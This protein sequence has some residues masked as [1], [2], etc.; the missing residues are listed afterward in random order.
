[1]LDVPMCLYV[2]ALVI[3]HRQ[4][5]ADSTTA[6]EGNWYDFGFGK[7]VVDEPGERVVDSLAARVF[8][9]AAAEAAASVRLTANGHEVD[10][11]D[12]CDTTTT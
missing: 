6:V 12:T 7:C 5:L 4:A 9:S 11:G 10:C 2:D 8:L 1:M 3:R